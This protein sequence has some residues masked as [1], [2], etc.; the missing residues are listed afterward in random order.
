MAKHRDKLKIV[1]LFLFLVVVALSPTI[2]IEYQNSKLLRQV[3]NESY[4]FKNESL[5]FDRS[6]PSKTKS[7]I[8]DLSEKLVALGTITQGSGTQIVE[9]QETIDPQRKEIIQANLSSQLKELQ[10][11]NAI[12]HFEIQEKGIIYNLKTLKIP[13]SLHK[14]EQTEL[15]EISVD[16][17]NISMIVLMDVETALIF[18]LHVRSDD[19]SLSLKNIPFKNFAQ[20]FGFEN[21]YVT[22]KPQSETNDGLDNIYGIYQILHDNYLISFYVSGSK[23]HFQYALH[24]A[25]KISK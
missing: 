13:D 25:V 21:D 9:Q 5:Y 19:E 2:L 7:D 1:V 14:G 10:S 6:E 18:N 23:E 17:K 20:Y 24:N 4:I 12:P 11:L 22:F 3:E 16:Y 8:E 15:W